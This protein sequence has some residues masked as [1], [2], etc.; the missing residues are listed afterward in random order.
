MVAGVSANLPPIPPSTL[1][2]GGA[3]LPT[4]TTTTQVQVSPSPIKLTVTQLVGGETLVTAQKVGGSSCLCADDVQ[5]VPGDP[6]ATVRK[7]QKVLGEAAEP[8]SS[9]SDNQKLLAQARSALAEAQ[10][11]IAQK[12]QGNGSGG[13]THPG[14][15]AYNAALAANAGTHAPQGVNAGSVSVFA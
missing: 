7:L 1:A 11:Q 13:A 15:S 8:G 2:G 14:A 3:P 9:S 5:P 4:Q 12:D 6:E 10:A